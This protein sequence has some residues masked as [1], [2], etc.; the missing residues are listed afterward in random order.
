MGKYLDNLVQELEE[1][2]EKARNDLKEAE[3][4]LE[5]TI[6]NTKKSI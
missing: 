6:E 4:K 1:M 5:Q 3:R 2:K